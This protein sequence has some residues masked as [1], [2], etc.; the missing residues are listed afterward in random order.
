MSVMIDKNVF[1]YFQIWKR[2]TE[3]YK[4]ILHTKFRI[5]IATLYK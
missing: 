1:A 5:R 2:N 3:A 4:I